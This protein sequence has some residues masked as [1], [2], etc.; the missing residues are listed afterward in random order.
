MEKPKEKTEL[1]L[2]ELAAIIKLSK[3]EK[4]TTWNALATAYIQGQ[5]D[6]IN[7]LKET[8]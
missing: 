7:R 1:L 3:L 2:K 8:I 6:Y 5:L 4:E